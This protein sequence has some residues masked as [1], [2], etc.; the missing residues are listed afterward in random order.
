M[1]PEYKNRQKVAMDIGGA[2]VLQLVVRGIVNNGADDASERGVCLLVDHAADDIREDI[3]SW[4]GWLADRVVAAHKYRSGED[5]L[6]DIVSN[7]PSPRTMVSGNVLLDYP[8]TL[9]T[10]EGML[11]DSPEDPV[12]V[13]SPLLRTS[14]HYAIDIADS[15]VTGLKRRAST[16][17]AR[18]VVDVFGL[19]DK[20]IE[21][22]DEERVVCATAL[23]N[24][25]LD[26]TCRYVE[27]EGQWAHF[28]TP[29]DFT[30]Y[31][32]GEYGRFDFDKQ[33][34]TLE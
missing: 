25:V 2:S 6:G 5:S 14:T 31:K 15:E 28:E 34:S 32:A 3:S 29:D 4:P 30:R 24:H 16:P 22:S 19:T 11:R 18:E 7:L 12:V 23:A 27:Y 8:T 21:L 20:V 9:N 33:P 10:V 26:L 1:G 17:A 13:G